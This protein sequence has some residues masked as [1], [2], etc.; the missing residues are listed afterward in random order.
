[1]KQKNMMKKTKSQGFTLLEILIAI[2]VFSFGLL[3]LA[4]MMTISVRNNHN[5]YLRTQANFYA[6]N[7]ADRMRANPVALWNGSYNGTAA[8]GTTVC[9]IGSPCDFDTLALYDM[10]NWARGIANTLPAGLGDITCAGP[11][12]LPGNLPTADAP[13][14]WIP[15]PPYPG[16]CTINVSW[17]EANG[18][19]VAET[20]T[21]TL[22]IQP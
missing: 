5:G 19:S 20:Q 3:G 15:A 13:S 2:L 22:V 18:N 17:T 14:I 21:V 4:G 16:L 10:E 12:G 7:M 9:T 6:D 1:M 11:G 8:T